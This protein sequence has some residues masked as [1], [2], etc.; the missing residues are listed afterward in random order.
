MK[1]HIQENLDAWNTR[2]KKHIHSAFYDQPSFMAGKSSL[3]EIE[4]ALL[5]SLDG[6]KVL[7]LQCHFGQ[8][9]LSLARLGAHVTAVDFS[10]DAINI[11]KG[12]SKEMKLPVEFI[13]ADVLDPKLKLEQD[14]DLVFMSYGVLVWHEDLAPLAELVSRSLSDDGRFLLVE[15]HPFMQMYDDATEHLTHSYFQDGPIS[16]VEEGTYADRN[17][18]EEITYTV[19]NHSLGEIMNSFI[20]AGLQVEFFQE[21]DFS[22]YPC[23]NHMIEVG[24][25][26]FMVEGKEGKVPMVFA[27]RAGK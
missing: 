9:S 15:F 23:F 7:H 26:R 3:K 17:D 19:W 24:S 5:P 1:K 2:A 13:C 14:F 12:L 11:A 20:G 21:Y 22:P 16:G 4:T 18:Q 25:S 6:L 8:D 27:L 10:Q